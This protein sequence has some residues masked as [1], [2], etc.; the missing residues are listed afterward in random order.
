M[1]DRVVR[2]GLRV[3]KLDA[4]L[5]LNNNTSVVVGRRVDVRER[6][7]RRSTDTSRTGPQDQEIT[8]VPEGVVDLDVVEGESRNREGDTR[9]LAEPEREDEGEVTTGTEERVQVGSRAGRDKGR[10]RGNVADHG[11]VGK[12]LL[13]RDAEGGVKV[14][15]EVV[16]LLHNQL[17]E[18]DRDLLE[19]VVHKVVGPPNGSILTDGTEEANIRELAAEPHVQ[20]VVGGAVDRGGNVLLT[21]ADRAV[22]T[23]SDR[24][25]G[26]PVRLLHGGDK[27]R[28]G[29][30]TTIQKSFDLG[31]SREINETNS[32]VRCGKRHL[33]TSPTKKKSKKKFLSGSS[34]AD[35][36]GGDEDS[37]L[38]RVIDLRFLRYISIL[39]SR[40]V[41][42]EFTIKFDSVCY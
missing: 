4:L 11:V 28:H 42:Y 41:R 23:E 8:P 6:C 24:D 3:D 2:K 5:A 21:K 10:H 37:I 12:L 7:R 27:P 22:V 40:D 1:N 16:E 38:K 18:R 9:V 15:P 36:R 14:E 31:E 32:W 35:H 20:N 29:V 34:S 30:G 19:E 17:V 39:I 33:D 13:C 25:V 26:E